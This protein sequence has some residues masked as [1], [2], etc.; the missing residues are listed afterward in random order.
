MKKTGNVLADFL[1]DKKAQGKLDKSTAN[2]L[3]P[4]NDQNIFKK[5]K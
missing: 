1:A 3:D 5:C 2:F 4:A